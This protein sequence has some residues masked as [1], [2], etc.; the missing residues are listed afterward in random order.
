MKLIHLHLH[1]ANPSYSPSPLTSHAPVS[2]AEDS[3]VES[4]SSSDSE[5]ASDLDNRAAAK[6]DLDSDEEDEGTVAGT[7]S[8]N[9]QVRSKNEEPDPAVLVPDTLEIGPEE[10]LERVG[11]IFSVMDNVVV[12]KGQTSQAERSAPT[13]LDAESVLVFD[14]R[15][16]LGYVCCQYPYSVEIAHLPSAGIRNIWT[17]SATSLPSEIYGNIPS[18]H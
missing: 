4:D 1:C 16:V 14:D 9:A 15:K 5:S 12:V 17:N 3:G 7:T 2:P 13:V 11:E 18:E 8:K 6:Y 10:T